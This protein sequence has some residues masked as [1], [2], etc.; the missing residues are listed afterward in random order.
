M[1]SLFIDKYKNIRYG[2]KCCALEF[3][4][5]SMNSGNRKIIQGLGSIAVEEKWN[6]SSSEEESNHVIPSR[7]ANRH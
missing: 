7:F 4:L 2:L 6:H 1:Q 3:S 5:F